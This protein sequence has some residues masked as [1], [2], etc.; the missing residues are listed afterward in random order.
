MWQVGGSRRASVGQGYVQVVEKVPSSPAS[1]VAP[2][3]A[4]TPAAA[5]TAASIQEINDENEPGWILG[6][7]GGSVA[8]VTTGTDDLWDKLLLD[9]G[10]VSTTCPHAWCSDISVN[11]GDKV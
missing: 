4:T 9:S 1:S 6:V 2:S 11:D 5:K 10:S 7:M 3:A 8:S